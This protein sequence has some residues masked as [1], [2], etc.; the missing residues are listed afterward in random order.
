MHIKVING[1]KVLCVRCHRLPT[2]PLTLANHL[3]LGEVGPEEAVYEELMEFLSDFGTRAQ[4][5]AFGIKTERWPI[6]YHGGV[7]EY[8]NSA[9]EATEKLDD[10]GPGYWVGRKVVT[11]PDAADTGATM[12]LSLN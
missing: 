2:A 3:P 11:W 12:N 5:L 10:Y 8:C 9:E 1:T 7:A 6:K 4:K